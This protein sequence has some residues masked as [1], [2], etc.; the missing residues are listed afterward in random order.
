MIT[1]AIPV[2]TPFYT[3]GPNK[4]EIKQTM[5]KFRGYYKEIKGLTDAVDKINVTMYGKFPAP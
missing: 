1:S 5:N 2:N 4:H 3:P